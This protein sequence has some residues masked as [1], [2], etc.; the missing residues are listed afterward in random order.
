MAVDSVRLLVGGALAS[1]VGIVLAASGS[2]TLGGAITLAGWL[3][4]VASVH[5]FGRGK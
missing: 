1:A 5:R 3:A 4:L 2:S